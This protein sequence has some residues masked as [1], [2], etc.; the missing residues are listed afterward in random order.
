[1]TATVIYRIV[2]AGTIGILERLELAG[3]CAR[4]VQRGTR[5]LQNR[6]ET[7]LTHGEAHRRRIFE[8]IRSN[9]RRLLRYESYES[10]IIQKRD[11]RVRVDSISRKVFLGD[12]RFY[13]LLER[14]RERERG[15]LTSRSQ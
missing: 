10:C 13:S 11:Y 15:R 5:R 14:E 1:V 2:N 7:R 9:N 8:S 12:L 3:N 6:P 4:T